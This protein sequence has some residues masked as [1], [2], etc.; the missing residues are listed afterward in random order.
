MAQHFHLQKQFDV[1]NFIDNIIDTHGDIVVHCPEKLS[2]KKVVTII[3]S[4]VGRGG[5]EWGGAQKEVGLPFPEL[6]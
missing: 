4:G 6:R 5:Q 2:G 1:E 3:A